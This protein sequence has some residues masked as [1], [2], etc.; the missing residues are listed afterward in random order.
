MAAP[1]PCRRLA[2][3]TNATLPVRSDPFSRVDID[4]STPPRPRFAGAV[5]DGMR[6]YD[7]LTQRPSPCEGCLTSVREASEEEFWMR[8][9][10]FTASRLLIIATL[11]LVGIAG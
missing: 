4:S 3:V 9:P 2:P 7:A 11:L 5:H 1:M 8:Q 10:G 6:R